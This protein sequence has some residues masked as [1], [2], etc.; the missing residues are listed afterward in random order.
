M[1]LEDTLKIYNLGSKMKLLIQDEIVSPSLQFNWR[2][3]DACADPCED[4][5]QSETCPGLS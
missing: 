3:I 4:S 5:S 1:S 2:L